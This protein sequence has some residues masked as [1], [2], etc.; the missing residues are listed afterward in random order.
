MPS[1]AHLLTSYRPARTKSLLSGFWSV[2]QIHF[3]KDLK[4]SQ[5]QISWHIPMSAKQLCKH[6]I[7]GNIFPYLGVIRECSLSGDMELCQVLFELCI[8]WECTLATE[9]WPLSDSWHEASARLRTANS[10]HRHTGA[11]LH[12]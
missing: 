9:H 2:L 10:N 4:S 8:P 12:E 6:G 7:A 5:I 11:V 3:C 1:Y